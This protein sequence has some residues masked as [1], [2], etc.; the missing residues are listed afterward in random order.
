M[1]MFIISRAHNVVQALP[2]KDK[3]YVCMDCGLKG[4]LETLFGE[5]RCTPSVYRSGSGWKDESTP[6]ERAALDRFE[7][8]LTGGDNPVAGEPCPTP[9]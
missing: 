3:Q 9:A 6:E 5:I 4:D 2:L 8:L 1:S 7:K